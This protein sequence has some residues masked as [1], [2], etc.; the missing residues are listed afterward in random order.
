MSVTVPLEITR[1]DVEMLADVLGELQNEALTDFIAGVLKKTQAVTE[2]SP[3]FK[4]IR[5][6]NPYSACDIS[7]REGGF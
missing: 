6:V 7:I 5:E 3:D 2:N 4:E 1:E